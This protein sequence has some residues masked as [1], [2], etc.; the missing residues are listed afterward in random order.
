MSSAKARSTSRLLS[1][2]LNAETA[3]DFLPHPRR[4]VNQRDSCP[5]VNKSRNSKRAQEGHLKQIRRKEHVQRSSTAL[6]E[7]QDRSNERVAHGIASE[8]SFETISSSLRKRV[9]DRTGRSLEKS[10]EGFVKLALDAVDYYYV[11]R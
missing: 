4:L 9:E 5:P 1:D 8:S 6:S 11:T 7:N 2:P 10:F 3:R